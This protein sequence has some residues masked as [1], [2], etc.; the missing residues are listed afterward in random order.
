MS[1]TSYKM[2]IDVEELNVKDFLLQPSAYYKVVSNPN[3][4]T[5]R[6]LFDGK[7]VDVVIAK[8]QYAFS[9]GA[10]AKEACCF[11]D[12]STDSFYRYC[13]KY[14]EFR[15]KIELLQTTPIFLAR[16]AIYNAIVNGD[17]KM[18]RWF[19]ERKCPEEFSI[20]GVLKYQLQQK[21]QRI[22]YLENILKQHKV[23]Y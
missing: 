6:P 18:V 1:I 11:A 14:P 10:T 12:I 23:N 5:G 21:T 3:I 20:N 16:V 17:L 13:N 9:I 22:E 19:L 8:L 15:N 7:N 2:K 4:K